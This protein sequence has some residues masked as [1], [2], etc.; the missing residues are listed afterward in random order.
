MLDQASGIIPDLLVRM[1]YPDT[2]LNNNIVN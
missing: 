1:K 2:V